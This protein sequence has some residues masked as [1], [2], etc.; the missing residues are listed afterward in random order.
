MA[1]GPARRAVVV[2]AVERIADSCGFGVPLMEPAGLRPQQAAW[3]E[4]KLAQDGERA[5]ADYMREHNSSSL[6]GLPAV[7]GERLG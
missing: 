3:V 4:R 2:V 1:G 7:D 6:D 5:L